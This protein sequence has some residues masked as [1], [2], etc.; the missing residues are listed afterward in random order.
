MKESVYSKQLRD[1]IKEI[2]TKPAVYEDGQIKKPERRPHVVLIP[3]AYRSLK[4][5]YDFYFLYYKTF[6][7]IECKVCRGQSISLSC[8]SQH[9]IEGLY[10][11]EHIGPVGNGYIVFFLDDYSIKKQAI[12]I[13]VFNWT[14]IKKWHKNEKSIKI[15]LLLSDYGDMFNL[16]KREKI[17]GKTHWNIVEGIVKFERY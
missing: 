12:V 13:P 6:Y 10:E 16:M 7:A 5:P 4:K 14:K 15:D 11:V 9:Q 2:L 17:N 3:D 1:D 8:V